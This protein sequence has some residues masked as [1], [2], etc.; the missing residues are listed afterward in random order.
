MTKKY[1]V[2]CDKCGK[3]CEQNTT[4][5]MEIRPDLPQN[6]VATVLSW[7]LCPECKSVFEEFMRKSDVPILNGGS[8]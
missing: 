8:L 6:Q 2:E 1:V 7:D 3:L 5:I 4:F